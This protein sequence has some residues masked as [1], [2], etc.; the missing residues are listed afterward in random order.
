MPNK[1]YCAIAH[2]EG[3]AFNGFVKQMQITN[4][5][6]KEE[7]CAAAFQLRS[8]GPRIRSFKK[9]WPLGEWRSR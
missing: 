7:G 6:E 4:T 9:R 2:D 5:G 3:W 1:V 8:I